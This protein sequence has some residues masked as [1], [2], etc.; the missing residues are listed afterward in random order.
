MASYG[1]K[2]ATFLLSALS[3]V[4]SAVSQTVAASN[5]VGYIVE[6]NTPSKT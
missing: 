1:V 3:Y 5:V 6:E 2:R 4:N